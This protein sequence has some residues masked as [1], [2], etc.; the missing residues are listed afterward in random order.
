MRNDRPWLIGRHE[1]LKCIWVHE[2]RNGIQRT[3]TEA[4]LMLS[5]FIQYKIS[6]SNL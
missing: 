6:I 2:Q 5:F 1:Y 3:N 4:Q